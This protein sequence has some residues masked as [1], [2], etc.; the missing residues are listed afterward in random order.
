MFLANVRYGSQP[1]IIGSTPAHTGVTPVTKICVT[2][3][4]QYV[5]ITSIYGR[6]G[7]EGGSSPSLN[8]KM[9]VMCLS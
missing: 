3:P 9:Y 6:R 2:K 1:A 4:S 8:T 5:Y 7:G